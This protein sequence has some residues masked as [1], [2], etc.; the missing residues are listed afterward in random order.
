[1]A[2][3]CQTCEKH[4]ALMCRL[5]KSTVVAKCFPVVCVCAVLHSD[6]VDHLYSCFVGSIGEPRN[7]GYVYLIKVSK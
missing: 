7:S 3:T 1:M 2:N 4:M 6:I 5:P